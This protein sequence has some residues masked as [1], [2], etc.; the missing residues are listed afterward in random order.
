[1]LNFRMRKHMA[2][3]ALPFV[4]IF[5]VVSPAYALIGLAPLVIR[6]G[7]SAALGTGVEISA[8]VHTALLG[9]SLPYMEITPPASPISVRI[10]LTEA[11]PIPEPD[12]PATAPAEQTSS[13]FASYNAPTTSVSAA[14]DLFVAGWSNPDYSVSIVSVSGDPLPMGCYPN[15]Y[16]GACT[17]DLTP[18]GLPPT[19]HTYSIYSDGSSSPTPTSA[20]PAGYSDDGAGGCALSD[21]RQAAPDSACDMARSGGALAMI[22]DPDCAAS[23]DVMAA[24]CEGVWCSYNSTDASGNPQKVTVTPNAS[25]G[26]DVSVVTQRQSGA[27]TVLD[28]SNISVS[29][30]GTVTAASGGTAT[31]SMSLDGSGNLTPSTGGSS[32]TPADV[33]F[34]SDYARAGDAQDAANTLSPGIDRIGDALTTS[35]SVADPTVPLDSEMPGWGS[36]FSGLTGWQLPVHGSACSTPSVDLS[37]VLGAGSVYTFD[38]HCALISD[39]F[40]ALQAAM[41]LVW[42]MLSVMIVLRA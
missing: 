15:N 9:V 31:G 4:F 21:A 16:L 6:M 26:S 32:V 38:G 18:V 7:G 23:P 22:S 20:C 3:I 25:G 40:Q 1:M 42:T 29:A 36:T 35:D 34:P 30:N 2:R 27:T 14:C 19:R 33:Q 11:A 28:T 10:P 37:A 13:C 17:Y 24:I 5:L 39:H 41:M 12:A 8:L